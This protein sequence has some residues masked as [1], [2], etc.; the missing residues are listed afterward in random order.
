MSYSF[1]ARAATREDVRQKLAAELD[2]VVAAQPIHAADREQALKAARSFLAI[3]PEASK[4]QDFYVSVSGSV[5]WTDGNV[6]TAA[7]VNVA[8]SLVR[9]ETA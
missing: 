2:A 8:A 3:L 7:S 9:K 6:I 5:G 1:V 4:E